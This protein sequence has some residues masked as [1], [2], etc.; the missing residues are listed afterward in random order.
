MSPRVVA[1]VDDLMDRSRL[2]TVAGIVWAAGPADPLLADADTVLVDVAA[3]GSG[4][5]AIRALA[6]GAFIVAFGPHVDAAALADARDA[7]ADRVL[8]RSRFFADPAAALARDE[9]TARA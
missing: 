4:I 2:G 6:P 3:H 9:G 5:G 7:G 8:P 1:L